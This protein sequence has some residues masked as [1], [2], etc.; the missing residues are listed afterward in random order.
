M[1]AA[2]MA[3]TGAFMGRLVRAKPPPTRMGRR[4]RTRIVAR[5]FI[6]SLLRRESLKTTRLK[7]E[8]KSL[9]RP[10]LSNPAKTNAKS[11]IDSHVHSAPVGEP[12]HGST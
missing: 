4:I 9:L 2:R 1:T 5:Y 10:F 11:I 7:T 8:I 3:I 6:S 12:Y